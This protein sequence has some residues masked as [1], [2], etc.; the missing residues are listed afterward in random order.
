MNFEINWNNVG[1]HVIRN[2]VTVALGVGIAIARSFGLLTDKS[3]KNE[4]DYSWWKDLAAD[5][6]LSTDEA[7]SLLEKMLKDELKG[8]PHHSLF[9]L[10]GKGLKAG[11]IVISDVTVPHFVMKGQ[12][13]EI[14]P[15]SSCISVKIGEYE[16]GKETQYDTWQ[17]I[18]SKVWKSEFIK[19]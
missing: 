4:V 9:E 17:G 12:M 14:G 11:D 16:E 3:S 6:K 15:F 7:D 5:E 10:F 2:M 1:A 8:D 18:G 19:K 13:F